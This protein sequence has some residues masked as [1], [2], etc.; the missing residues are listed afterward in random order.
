MDIV[1]AYDGRHGIVLA[2][3]IISGPEDLTG[4]K[5]R[6]ESYLMLSSEPELSE[7]LTRNLAKTMRA[8]HVRIDSDDM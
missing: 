1:D 7:R 8:D 5:F 3:V 4:L 2:N 6:D